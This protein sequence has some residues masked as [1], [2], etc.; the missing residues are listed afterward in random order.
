MKSN[1]H[2]NPYNLIIGEL[3]CIPLPI[4]IYPNCPTTN[5]YVVNKNDTFESIAK[6]FNVTPLQ[7]LYANYGIELNDLYEDQILCIP[8]APSPVQILINS[9][10]RKLYVFQNGNVLRTYTLLTSDSSRKGNFIILNKQIDNINF[11]AKYLG[12]SDINLGI[13]G[14]TELQNN[15]N[16][17]SLSNEDI[18][19]LFNLVSVGTPVVII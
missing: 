2:I 15:Q 12:L 14:V 11:G 5:Y 4:Q 10:D 17:F 7:L 13:Q 9:N 6:Y 1:P 3:I 16:G 18:I 8:V 19:E